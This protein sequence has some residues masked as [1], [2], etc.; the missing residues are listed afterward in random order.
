MENQR[1][2]VCSAHWRESLSSATQAREFEERY[3]LS[4]MLSQCLARLGFAKAEEVLPFLNPHLGLLHDP[5]LM[6]GM[7]RAVERLK[8]AIDSGEGI[9][10]VTD[11]DVDGTMSSLILQSVLRAFGHQNLSYHIPDRKV[12]GYGFSLLASEKAVADGIGLIVTADIG[13]RDHAAIGYAQSHGVDV[14]VMDHHLPEGEGVPE[15]AYAVLCPPQ[16]ACNYPNKSLAACGVALKFAQA[17]LRKHPR[18]EPY[19]L[20]IM[21]LAALGTVA[22]IVSLREPE[23][24]AIVALGLR[25]LN[26]ENHGPGLQALLDVSQAV[27]GEI[28]SETIGFR[29]G[30]RI[31]AAGRMATATHIIE[32]L[33]AA[34]SV[35]AQGLAALLND[36]NADRQQVQAQMIET[37]MALTKGS[38]DPFVVVALP[39]SDAWHAGISGIVAGCIR[40][41][42]N[43][44]V[45]IATIEGKTVTGSVRSTPGVHA[46]KALNA[47]SHLLLRYGGHA[48]AAGFSFDI[49]HLEEVKEG[50]KENVIKQLGKAFEPIVFDVDLVLRPDEIDLKSFEDLERLEPCGAQNPK[51]LVCLRDVSL[52]H[53]RWLKELHFSARIK[54]S[55]LNLSCIWFSAPQIP[56]SLL[57]Q[58]VHLL[59]VLQKEKWNGRTQY[60]IM[61]SDLRPATAD[62]FE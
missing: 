6:L 41:A 46:V 40:E 42:L 17:F 9:R 45:A 24:R 49:E 50:L 36:M 60:K 44:P 62:V 3:G 23:N 35:E 22:D 52:T 14:I 34:N 33:Q 20:S 15:A 25:S 53:V 39:A 28:T 12:E 29:I 26:L 56:D 32:L 55:P 61:L 10:I 21:K 19:L 5:F 2:S 31:N 7:Q 58:P 51:P 54:D 4:P 43:R 16:K 38:T 47:V 1:V 59:G 57:A 37:A 8:R 11:Y 13:V 48:A 18:F 30:P 27:K